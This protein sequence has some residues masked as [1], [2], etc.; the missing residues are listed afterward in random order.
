MPAPS[1]RQGGVGKHPRQKEPPLPQQGGREGGAPKSQHPQAS[2]GA[3]APGLLTFG[4]TSFVVLCRTAKVLFHHLLFF[5]LGLKNSPW[6]MITDLVVSAQTPASPSNKILDFSLPK[7][8]LN[9]N[10]KTVAAYN[11]P[12]MACWCTR[13]PATS[14]DKQGLG[15]L[16]ILGVA[17]TEN[18]HKKKQD[19]M[20][21]GLLDKK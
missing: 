17:G 2:F 11:T 16:S 4:A 6:G 18:I 20:V 3:P 12:L 9:H 19:M 8:A 10:T 15:A 5:I 14:F 21:L 7:V 13:R 1:G